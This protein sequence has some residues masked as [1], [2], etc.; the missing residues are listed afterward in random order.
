MKWF[1]IKEQAAG[2]KRLIL[3]WYLYK[4]FGVKVLYIIAFGVTFFT[5]IFSSKI[6][7]YSKKYL[8]IIQDVT[9]IKPNIIN[10]FKHVF[11]YSSS[12]VDKL[13]VYSGEFDVNKLAFDSEKD[14][15]QLFSD[16]K[17][18]NGIF[19]ICSH[20]GNIEVLQ[21]MFLDK[22]TCPDFKVNIF[23]SNTQSQ[24]F[25]DFI[26]TIK[27]DFPV[28]VFNIED[29]GLNTGIELKDNL[30]NGEIVF[31]AGDRLAEN[32]EHQYITSKVFSHKVNFP[33]G[34]FKLA[35]L[36]DVP[37]YFISAIKQGKQ[38]KIFLEKQN[39]LKEKEL[40][41]SYTK[42]LEKIIKTNPFQFFHFYDYFN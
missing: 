21:A 32:N 1:E 37:T 26:K 8:N 18:G 14:K 39:N 24:I 31:I 36:M 34:T 35:K 9:D 41:S 23:L 2:K 17:Q 13:L 11:N 33:K 12:L 40:I 5:F 28:K 30:D 25:N 20:I 38:Y 10:Q 3:S 29:I 6:R 4:L 7:T 16:I 27:L 22:N 19:F 15:I 42:F